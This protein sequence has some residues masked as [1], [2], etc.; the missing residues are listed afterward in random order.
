MCTEDATDPRQPARESQGGEP[1]SPTWDPYEPLDPHDAGTLPI[2]PYR[3][4]RR[5][6]GKPRQ[7]QKQG[8]ESTILAALL[9]I[10][11]PA[12]ASGLA[13]PEFAF[14][15]QVTQNC[16]NGCCGLHKANMLYNQVHC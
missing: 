1:A 15:L 7:K 2:K 16:S 5:R 6:R 12:G 13:F 10:K 3:R 14:A 8:V 9:G 4:M 11:T